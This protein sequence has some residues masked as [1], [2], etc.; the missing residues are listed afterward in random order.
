LYASLPLGP[1][2]PWRHWLAWTPTD[3]GRREAIGMVSAFRNGSTV[4]IE[5]V[6]VVPQRRGG[7]IGAAL[8]SHAA[9]AEAGASFVV[10]GPTPESRP[11]YERLGFTLEPCVPDR[12]F[13]LPSRTTRPV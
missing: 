4:L 2:A 6:G 12:Q 9:H 10:L 5:H 7:G 11:L 13:Y 1:T 8:V 3:A